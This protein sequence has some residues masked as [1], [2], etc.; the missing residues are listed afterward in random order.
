MITQQF[1]YVMLHHVERSVESI[2]HS[3][4]ILR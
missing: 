3:L 2:D 4:A 1:V